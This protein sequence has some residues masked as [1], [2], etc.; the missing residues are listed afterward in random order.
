MGTAVTWVRGPVAPDRQAEVIERYRAAIAGGLP[1]DIDQT[2][3]L[4]EGDELNIV[5]VW[6]RREDLDAYLATGEEPFARRL[7]REAGGDPIV[8]IFELIA[9][10]PDLRRD[11]PGAAPG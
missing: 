6:P 11:D 7:I 2:M 5:T 3:L 10:Q 4:R 1:P 9:R 8:R